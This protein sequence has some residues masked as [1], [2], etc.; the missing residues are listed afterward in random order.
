MHTAFSIKKM[1]DFSQ[2]LIKL[3]DFSRFY[4]FFKIFLPC[5]G[6]YLKIQNFHLKK[7]K[8]QN[9]KKPGQT[10]KNRKTGKS[11]KSREKTGKQVLYQPCISFPSSKCVKVA[12]VA[13]RGYPIN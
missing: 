9:K 5:V 1:S 4:R 12:K 11:L 13:T 8:K 6:K 2:T 7:K 3:V 10:E